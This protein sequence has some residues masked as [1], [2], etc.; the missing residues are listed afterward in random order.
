L[1]G[2]CVVRSPLLRWWQP[3]GVPTGCTRQEIQK[4]EVLA[5]HAL[6][7]VLNQGVKNAQTR[8]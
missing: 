3:Q 6:L 7:T 1:Q 8:K 4:Q 2:L 5:Q